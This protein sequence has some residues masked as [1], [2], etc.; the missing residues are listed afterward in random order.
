MMNGKLNIERRKR[1][2]SGEIK[3][4]APTFIKCTECKHRMHSAAGNICTKFECY[5]D[6]V[7]GCGRGERGEV[8]KNCST[9]KHFVRAYIP[10]EVAYAEW[11]YKPCSYGECHA[12]CNQMYGNGNSPCCNDHYSCAGWQIGEEE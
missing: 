11:D 2:L 1:T 5:L 10:V 8:V 9:C 4:N 12:F 7:K 6:E 3:F